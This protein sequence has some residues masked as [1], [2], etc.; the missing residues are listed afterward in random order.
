[1]IEFLEEIDFIYI[2]SEFQVGIRFSGEPMTQ[3]ARQSHANVNQMKT[4][5]NSLQHHARSCY[6]KSYHNLNANPKCEP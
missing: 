2:S 4:R 5:K 6:I 1:M 3:H